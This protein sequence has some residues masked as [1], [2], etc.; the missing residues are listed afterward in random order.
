[1]ETL[2]FWI[3]PVTGKVR[4]DYLLRFDVYR[5][6]ADGWCEHY[7]RPDSENPYEYEHMHLRPECTFPYWSPWYKTSVT[8][9]MVQAYWD[10]YYWRRYMVRVTDVDQSYNC[11]GYS[12]GYDSSWITCDGMATIVEEEYVYDWSIYADIEVVDDISH[13]REMPEIVIDPV[14]GLR[15]KKFREKCRDSGI[16]QKNN[17]NRG[18]QDNTPYRKE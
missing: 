16:Y 18:F 17:V 9:N 2:L 4:S 14:Y 11:H 13:S 1:L 7:G 5:P 3:D 12:T 10:A 8:L 15:I 6:S